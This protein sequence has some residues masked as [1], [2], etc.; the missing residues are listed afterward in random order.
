MLMFYKF[1]ACEADFPILPLKQQGPPEN[2]KQFSPVRY[3]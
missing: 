3:E 1:Q 2:F